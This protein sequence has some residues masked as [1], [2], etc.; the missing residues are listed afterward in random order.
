M[1]STVRKLFL[2]L[3][4]SDLS[5]G[6]LPQLMFGVI[7]AV[8]LKMSSTGNYN[9]VS[10]CPTILNCIFLCFLSSRH[11]IFPE[12]YGHCS[13]QTSR[14]F[15][16]FAISGACHFQTC[17]YGIGDFMVYKCCNYLHINFP[18]ERLWNDSHAWTISGTTHRTIFDNCW[19]IFVSIK[20]HNITKIRY[21]A[22]FRCK[23][24]KQ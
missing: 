19:H 4:F 15:T 12:Y 5:V 2:S 3:A 24:P 16:P 6:I 11:R 18:S 17:C 8:M 23:I 22:N 10:F 1:P 20:L 14:C 7:L 9:F 21:T 13:R